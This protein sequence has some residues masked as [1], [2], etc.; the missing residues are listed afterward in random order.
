MYTYEY[1]F[2]HQGFSEIFELHV[3]MTYA[4]WTNSLF[5]IKR[6][7]FSVRLINPDCSSLPSEEG[8]LLFFTFLLFFLFAH[9][10]RIVHFSEKQRVSTKYMYTKSN[11]NTLSVSYLFQLGR[12]WQNLFVFQVTYSLDLNN[13]EH[14]GSSSYSIMIF[15]ISSNR[16]ACR[17]KA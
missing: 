17:K 13:S 5:M 14:S 7:H 3:L 2:Q 16:F 8:T 9:S 6:L 4:V 1:I 11:V 12:D 15:Q 10:P